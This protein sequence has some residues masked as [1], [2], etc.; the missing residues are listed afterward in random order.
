GWLPYIPSKG[1]GSLPY[2]AADQNPNL[3]RVYINAQHDYLADRIYLIGSLVT[4][5][6]A[7]KPDPARRRSIVAITEGVPNESA[8]RDLLVKWID[9]TVRA[10][11]EVAVPDD[12]GQ[13][14]APIHLIFFNSFEQRLLLE[15]LGRHA[16]EILAATPVYDFVTQLAAFD[17]PVATFLDREIRELKNYPFVCQSLQAVAAT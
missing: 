8:E 15:A 10:I 17:S 2:S 4:G 16:R 6:V 5:N 13:P 1:Y 3:V 11:A 12:E 9:G 7:G 14:N